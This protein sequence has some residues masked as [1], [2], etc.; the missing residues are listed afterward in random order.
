MDEL[1]KSL[2]EMAFITKNEK[3]LLIKLKK[4]PNLLTEAELVTL[5][6]FFLKEKNTPGIEKAHALLVRLNKA[7]GRPTSPMYPPRGGKRSTKRRSRTPKKRN[8]KRK[9]RRS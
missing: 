5:R 2:S 7:A 9:T 1:I 3:M 8:P 6:T 4:N